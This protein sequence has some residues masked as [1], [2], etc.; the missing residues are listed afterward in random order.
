MV[1][2]GSLQPGQSV[3]YAMTKNLARARLTERLELADAAWDA[4]LRGEVDLS[5]RRL[6][7]GRV[8]YLATRRRVVDRT[9][10]KPAVTTQC[11]RKFAA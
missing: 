1:D 9:P 5:Q 3:V 8:A 11:Y 2:L 10:V 4:A 6:K 7:D